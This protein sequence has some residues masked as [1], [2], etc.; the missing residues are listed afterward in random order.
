MGA[1]LWQ[2]GAPNSHIWKGAP[3]IDRLT[4]G[5]VRPCLKGY[6]EFIFEPTGTACGGTG[7][8]VNE[9][10]DFLVRDDLKLNSPSNYKAMFQGRYEIYFLLLLTFTDF[11]GWKWILFYWPNMWNGYDFSWLRKEYSLK[12]TGGS[13]GQ[14]NYFFLFKI[15]WS[16]THGLSKMGSLSSQLQTVAEIHSLKMGR[17][18]AFSTFSIGK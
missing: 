6:N 2:R 13:Q 11:E 3:V 16:P 7:F 15:C 12:A 5:P 4:A 8:Y 9:K 14:K 18:H 10:L 1:L 17:F